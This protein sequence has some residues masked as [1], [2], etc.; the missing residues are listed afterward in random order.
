MKDRN[1]A[2]LRMLQGQPVIPVV[3]L[4]RLADAVPLAEALVKGGLSTIEI[5]LRSD[6]GLDAIRLVSEDVPHAAIG[7]GTVLSTRQFEQAEVAGARFVVS[8]GTTQ[9][10]LEAARDSDM[11]FLPGA[12]TPSEFMSMYEEGYSLLKFFPAEPSGGAQYL[13]ALAAPLP[14][15]RFCPTGGITRANAAGYLELP[16]VVSV[17]G[18]W[19]CPLDLVRDGQWGR[20]TELARDAA[21]IPRD[22]P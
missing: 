21:G 16:N 20:I 4:E 13:A 3:T 6:I 9:E 19:P 7:A 17:G 10:L 11:P 8:P 5:T 1:L 18:S 22:H 12:L 2:L 15:I 14:E